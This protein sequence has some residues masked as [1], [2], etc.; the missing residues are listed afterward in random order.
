MSARTRRRKFASCV[1]ESI[2]IRLIKPEVVTDFVQNRDTNLRA[3]PI[4]AAPFLTLVVFPCFP[5]AR[6]V[7]DAHPKEM[8]GFKSL[9][10]A[11][12]AFC[13]RHAGVKAAQNVFRVIKINA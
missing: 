12:T 4:A 9:R 3:D 5:T 13:E 2:E 11:H 6:E 7:E 8:N 1:A 10:V